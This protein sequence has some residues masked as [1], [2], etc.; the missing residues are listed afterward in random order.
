MR[1]DLGVVGGGS[2][3]LAAATFA[4]GMGARVVL[5]EAD[6]LGG[7]CTW[8]GCVP[9]KAL[10]HA[11]R[12]VHQARTAGWLGSGDVDFSA[13]MRGVR[14]SVRRVSELEDA[15]SLKARGIEVVFGR[16][17][18]V[19]PGSVE[20]DGRRWEAR[21]FVICTGAEPALPPIPGLREAP[22]LTYRTVFDLDQQPQ[23]LLV[24]GG[25]PVGVELAQAL[26]R[27]GSRVT[28]LE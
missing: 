15:A 25:G 27:L 16:A 24:L 8:T 2:T 17:R 22:H 7:D 18:F 11:A 12:V 21:R 1:Y 26:Q 4:A 3:G 5:V 6:R 9:S 23:R 19:D 13:M 10:V 28:I 14:D 20:A